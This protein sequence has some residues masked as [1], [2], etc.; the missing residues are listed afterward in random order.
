MASY[1]RWSVLYLTLG[2]N[3]PEV[4]ILGELSSVNSVS[5]S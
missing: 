4:G 5:E 2:P 1:V 3:V